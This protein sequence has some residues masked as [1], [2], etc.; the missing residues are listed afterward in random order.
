LQKGGIITIDAIG[1]QKQSSR[2]DYR[3][4]ADYVIAL[5][6]NQ[7]ALFE[8]IIEFMEGKNSGCCRG[9]EQLNGT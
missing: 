7:G 2:R 8:Q 9:Y 5:K 6:Q 4:K 3:K 1:C